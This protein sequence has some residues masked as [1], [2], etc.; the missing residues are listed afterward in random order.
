MSEHDGVIQFLSVISRLKDTRRQGWVERGIR[1][2]E[3]V[4]D[5]MY[6]VA[7][8]TFLCL[9]PTLDKTRMM[10][11][12]LCHDMAEALV[13]DITP[14]MQVPKAE[15]EARERAAM[16]HIVGLLPGLA[17][18]QEI[19]GLWEEYEAQVTPEARF[20]KDL[21]LLEMVSQAHEYEKTEKEYLARGEL[22]TFFT[23]VDKIR[24]PWA[25]GVAERLRDTR[26]TY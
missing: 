20:L 4:A 21:D 16:D 14:A 19:R 25:R 2:P 22:D 5:H 13:G 23:A 18:A 1:Q 11:L 6:R 9:D 12:A 24:H 3:S 7:T 10:K 17:T 26:E 15:K 8:M